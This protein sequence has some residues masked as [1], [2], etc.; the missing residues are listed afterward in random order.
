MKHGSRIMI[1]RAT[2]FWNSYKFTPRTNENTAKLII[3]NTPT[4]YV[5]RFT[6]WYR[7]W[8]VENR[9]HR[10]SYH[11]C[12][13]NSRSS[14]PGYLPHSKTTITICIF[15]NLHIKLPES[16]GML[17]QILQVANSS[18]LFPMY[19]HSFSDVQNTISFADSFCISRR[20]H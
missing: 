11:I 17:L 20:K 15:P 6:K 3:C 4:I 12:S 2:F 7:K 1:T 16:C 19:S 5:S 13:E 14:F 18:I 8:G 10:T 9:T